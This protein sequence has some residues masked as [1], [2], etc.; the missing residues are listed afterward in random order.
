M[1][2]PEHYRLAEQL[3][4]ETWEMEAD[5]LDNNADMARR[6]AAAQVH[7]TLALAA[8]TAVNTAVN[9]FRDDINSD[10][11]AE[12]AAAMYPQEDPRRG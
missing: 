3:L 8:A 1:T 12:W 7:A 6:I 2:G 9:A 10:D 11:V 4:S 5:P